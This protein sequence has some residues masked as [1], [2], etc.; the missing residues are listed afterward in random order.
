MKF[1]EYILRDSFVH[2]LDPRA[3]LVWLISFS[4]LVFL[5][6]T[7]Y[8]ITG[9][10][11]FTLFIG[12]IAK[13]PRKQ[14]W[15][16]TKI[17]IILMPIAYI[18]LYIFLVGL[19]FNAIFGGLIFTGKFLVLI[20][21]AVIFT[22]TT[23]A[24]DLLLGLTKLK[25]PYSFAFMLTIAIRFIPVITKEINNVINAQRASRYNGCSICGFSY[26]FVIGHSW[27]SGSKPVTGNFSSAYCCKCY[28][29]RNRCISWF[30][31]L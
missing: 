6:S 29:G 8:I 19:N 14:F 27:S 3:K 11:I 17:F 22:M 30:M 20:F 24:R 9:V 23:S 2:K 7:P 28:F 18:L 4:C 25:V 13:L 21:A 26:I 10:L 12:I 5:T 15:D 1:Y 16:S 31:A